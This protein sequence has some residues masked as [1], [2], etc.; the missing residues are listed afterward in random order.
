M[1]TGPSAG[2]A[3]MNMVEKL[4]TAPVPKLASP[5]EFGPTM[6]SDE[7]PHDAQAVLLTEGREGGDGLPFIHHLCNISIIVEM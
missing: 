2:G 7:R 6:R 1:P 4:A 3:S 5:C